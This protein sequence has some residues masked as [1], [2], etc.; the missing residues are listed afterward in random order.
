MQTK[1]MGL[2][3]FFLLTFLNALSISI[4]FISTNPHILFP[5]NN[6]GITIEAGLY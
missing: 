3:P 2:P 5:K 4:S 6:K 1:I